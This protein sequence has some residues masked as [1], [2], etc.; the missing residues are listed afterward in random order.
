MRLL[1]PGGNLK[2]PEE[3]DDEA[4]LS[5]RMNQLIPKFPALL[6]K[7]LC[8]KFQGKSKGQ[9]K[10]PN[11]KYTSL[12]ALFLTA[13]NNLWCSHLYNCAH[14][15]YILVY[16]YS[17][18]NHGCYHSQRWHDT[19]AKLK[20]IR[21]HLKIKSDSKGIYA[22]FCADQPSWLQTGLVFDI[23]SFFFH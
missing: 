12:S 8:P 3:T 7:R 21:Q 19:Y 14:L 11:V 2:W 13:C 9:G 4:N 22:F 16:K 5:R 23:S 15:Q 1:W 17:C 18:M 20:R 6:K 10:R